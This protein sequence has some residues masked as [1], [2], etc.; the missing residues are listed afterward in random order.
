MLAF[1]CYRVQVQVAVRFG[2]VS[3]F[4]LVLELTL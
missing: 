1:A 2:L 4:K 3:G